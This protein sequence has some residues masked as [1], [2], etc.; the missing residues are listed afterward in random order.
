MRTFPFPDRIESREELARDVLYQKI[1]IKD[2]EDIC[3]KA[4][5]RGVEAAENLKVQF[6]YLDIWNIAKNS[7]V[8]VK[9]FK[10]DRVNGNLRVFGEYSS[11]D[12]NIAIYLGSIKKWAEANFLTITEAEELVMA[13]EFF[14]FL[15]CKK[16][17]ETSALYQI[18]V[19]H[20]WKLS[21]WK[22]G[23]RALS[24]I[25]AHGFARTFFE[26]GGKN[27]KT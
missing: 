25:A 8:S 5:N 24:E 2:R 3:D 4:W 23:I 26:N 11:K 13:H 10:E 15:E 9:K 7:G 16:I 1:P 18:P 21:F 6:P 27:G 14:H 12:D 20:I 19:L 22:S 17:G